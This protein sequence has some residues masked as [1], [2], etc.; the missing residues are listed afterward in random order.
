MAQF[1]DLFTNGDE[2]LN[3]VRNWFI[4]TYSGLKVVSGAAQGV[5]ISTP[6]VMFNSTVTAGAEQ[7]TK[8]KYGTFQNGAYLI[9]PWI[10][11]PVNSGAQLN[12]YTCQWTTVQWTLKRWDNGSETALDGAAD[13]S[14]PSGK[15]VILYRT[16]GKLYFNVNGTEMW[17][18]GYTEAT[19]TSG[20]SGVNYYNAGS[21]TAD[22]TF[23]EFYGGDGTDWTGGGGASA[24]GG[25][26]LLGSRRNRLTI[27]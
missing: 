8:I 6:C 15:T 26:M 24:E 16:G 20:T 7:F 5:A 27:P 18:S 14:S 23:T 9:N 10:C 3:G 19:Y 21:A 22:L 1:S 25:G 2:T 12:G 11:G 17:P 13:A 4:H